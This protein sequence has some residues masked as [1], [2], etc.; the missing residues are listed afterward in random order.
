M[1]KKFAK[2]TKAEQQR[3]ETEYHRMKPEDF[4][5]IMASATRHSPNALLLPNRLVEKLK[6]VAERQG[7][8]EYRS[9]VKTWIEERLREEARSL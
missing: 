7:K 4:G 8:S 6:T 1:R 5:E 9:M 2:L 3:V